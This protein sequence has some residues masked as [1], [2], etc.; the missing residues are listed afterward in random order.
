MEQ[1]DWERVH[2]QVVGETFASLDIERAT[3]L[4]GVL[5]DYKIQYSD[6]LKAVVAPVEGG[7]PDDAPVLTADHS[8]QVVGQAFGLEADDLLRRY[9]ASWRS[10]R[11]S[12]V[13]AELVAEL[14]GHRF[15]GRL[16]PASDVP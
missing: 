2:G 13:V 4:V 16:C 1:Y 6:A 10:L 5:S 9:R 15:V 14:E 7:A 3:A 12:P 8:A 11:S